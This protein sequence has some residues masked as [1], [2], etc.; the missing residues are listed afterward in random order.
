MIYLFSNRTYGVPFLAAAARYAR[1]SG[2]EITVVFSGR[3]RRNDGG[4]VGVLRAFA[5][6]WRSQRQVIGG[7]PVIVSDD[8][9]APA[10]VD[11]IQPQDAGII[12]GFDQ[13]FGAKAI[14][15]FTSFVNVHPSLLPYYRGP[16]PAYWCVD[17][18]ETTSGFTI[19]TVTTKIDSGEIHYQESLPIDPADDASTLTDRI[20][21]LAIPAF[22][23]WLDHIAQGAPWTPRL[24]D[25]G[26]LYRRH[27]D[28]RSFRDAGA[29]RRK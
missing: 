22:E 28:Y 9:N 7:L 8:V 25:A 21:L 3:Q 6:R 13:I 18:L 17:N 12:A 14:E 10:F 24:V 4:P 1:S 27:V 20:A 2:T 11:L 5:A 19:H 26:A 29:M 15:K 16:E 23:Q